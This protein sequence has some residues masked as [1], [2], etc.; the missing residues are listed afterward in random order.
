MF[1]F[2]IH[3]FLTIL[4]LT[5]LMTRLLLSI[6]Y[7]VLPAVMQAGTPW[8]K[9][10]LT[11]VDPDS[12]LTW[13]YT[14]Q[15]FRSIVLSRDSSV[16]TPRFKVNEDIIR[17]REALQAMCS[18]I[19]SHLNIVGGGDDERTAY[20]GLP[21]MMN[22][23]AH[24][25]LFLL[26][27]KSSHA[28]LIERSLFNAVLQTAGRSSLPFKQRDRHASFE[29]LMAVNGLMYATA[30]EDLYVNLYSNS[31]SRISLGSTSFTFDQITDM[32]ADGT[33]KMR[34]SRLDHPV[35][36]RL[37]LRMPDWLTGQM[38]QGF[39]F[40]YSHPSTKLPAVFVSGHELE[41]VKTDESGYVVIDRTWQS[42]DEVYFVFPLKPTVVRRVSAS[43][44]KAERG[45]VA[46]QIGPLIM[47]S[48][49]S[50]HDYY[51]STT[52]PMEASMGASRSG[53]PT[54]HFQLYKDTGT[55]AD[56]QAEATPFSATPFCE[57]TENVGDVWLKECK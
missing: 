22:M 10:P 13:S 27:G 12:V 50:A 18:D 44:S 26:T 55:P 47:A 21:A 57:Q 54:L 48:D 41:D 45:Q 1:T 8:L 33:V 35:H 14:G 24:A 37:H 56:A 16:L 5:S 25:Y 2:S 28:D 53:L 36:F 23:S 6:L 49:Q 3:F 15:D 7:I 31:T 19:T 20:Q 17:R 4:I 29:S 43:T 11:Y 46:L 42:L 51:F 30:R 39:P 40:A 32:P 52:S 34:I 9:T 38:P